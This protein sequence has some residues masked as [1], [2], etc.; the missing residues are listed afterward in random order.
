MASPTSPVSET[1]DQ[2]ADPNAKRTDYYQ[3]VRHEVL[4]LVPADA[5]RILDV[6]CAEGML[7]A[8]LLEGGASEVFGIEY[9]PTVGA[10][11]DAPHRGPL[12]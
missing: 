9:D 12:R 1:P 4:A 2:V 8:Q 7:G 3:Q 11:A 5:R 10:R 6:G